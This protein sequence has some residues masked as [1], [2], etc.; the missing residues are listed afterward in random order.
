MKKQEAKKKDAKKVVMKKIINKAKPKK[1]NSKPM[2]RKDVRAE[3]ELA[4]E[5]YLN[6]P[7]IQNT[8]ELTQVIHENTACKILNKFSNKTKLIKLGREVF[9]SDGA[10]LIYLF[11]R[12]WSLGGKMPIE[13][14]KDDEGV[15]FIMDEL[16]RIEYGILC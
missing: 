14:L 6:E 10:F 8:L 9:G 3:V 15:Q 1:I 2:F 12:P 5:R 4:V 11:D 13:F 16:V 7:N